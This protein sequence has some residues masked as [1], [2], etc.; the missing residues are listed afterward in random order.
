MKVEKTAYLKIR[1]DH[2]YSIF[3]LFAVATIVRYAAI[4]W[5]LLRG[6]PRAAPDSDTLS[7]G[8]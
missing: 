6:R 2:L 7:S 8:L 3:I 4:L 1:F 5:Q